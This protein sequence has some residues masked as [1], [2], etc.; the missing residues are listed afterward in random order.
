M[1]GMATKKV[2]KRNQIRKGPHGGMQLVLIEDVPHLG[3]R[4]DVVEVKPG[5]GRNYLLPQG[6]ALVPTDH[7]LRLLEQ[8]KIRIQKALEA[9]VADLK[10]LASQIQRLD[11]LLIEAAA[12]ENGVLYGSVGPNEISQHLRA[13]NLAVDPSMVVMDAHI[14]EADGIVRDITLHLGH[15][16]EAT[17]KVVVAPAR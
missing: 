8:Y 3:K 11:A 5:Y 2:R 14:K 7:N 9:K 13:K 1:Q 16:V 10:V 6:L 17:I 4:G 12:N 15:G